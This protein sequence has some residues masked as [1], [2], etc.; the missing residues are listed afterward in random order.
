MF[1]VDFLDKEIFF[2]LTEE[3]LKLVFF[4]H[5]CS[6]FLLFLFYDSLQILH[7]SIIFYKLLI[8]LLN[9]SFEVGVFNLKPDSLLNHIL[10]LDSGF[11]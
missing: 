8:F 10:I 7:I 4:V 1:E 9:D 6:Y 3:G 5:K 11:T 2:C